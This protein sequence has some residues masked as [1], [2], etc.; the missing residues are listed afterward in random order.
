MYIEL[1][2]FYIEQP[3]PYPLV[4]SDITTSKMIFNDA[5]SKM[6]L[7]KLLSSNTW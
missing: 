5:N 2:S 3:V 1:L 4:H 6:I 7:S